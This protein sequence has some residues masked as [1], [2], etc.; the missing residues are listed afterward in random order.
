MEFYT[1]IF[2][3]SQ[4]LGLNLSQSRIYSVTKR[5]FY[6]FWDAEPS[7]Y[8]L[9]YNYSRDEGIFEEGNKEII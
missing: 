2:D 8:S 4:T 1:K 7:S 6:D 9:E 3:I 5:M